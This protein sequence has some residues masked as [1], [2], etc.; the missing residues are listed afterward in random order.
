MERIG[1]P[2]FQSDAELDRLEDEWETAKEARID[3]GEKVARASY[4]AAQEDDAPTVEP[5]GRSELGRLREVEDDALETYRD[6]LRR[7]R[8]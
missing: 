6:A 1:G 8:D 4:D 7:A 3:H 2:V 5:D